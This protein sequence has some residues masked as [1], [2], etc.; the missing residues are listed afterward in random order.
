MDEYLV[1]YKILLSVFSGKNLGEEFNK[2]I[3]EN[4]ELNI[5]KI[6]D[7]S[8]GVL[9]Y[10]F[11]LDK[12]LGK[13]YKLKPD[14]NILV[15][16]FIA[17]YEIKYTKKPQY[18]ISNECVNL[19][20]RLTNNIKIKNFVNAI[21]RN[22][23]RSQKEIESELKNNLEYSYNFPL[24]LID[25]IKINNPDKYEEIIKNLNSKSKLSLR[26]NIKKTSL[27][28]YCQVL[29]DNNI[30]YN[31][32]D[33]T[34]ILY[35]NIKIENIPLFKEGFVS[36]QDI[37]A[38]KLNKILEFQDNSYVLDA[39]AAPGG[40]TCQ[41]LENNNVKLLAIDIDKTRIK[42][43]EQNL[44]R[45]DLD[46]TVICGDASKT[47]WWNSHK[48]DTI[49][50]DLPCSATGT[51]KKNPD[52]KINRRDTDIKNFVEKQRKIILNLWNILKDDGCLVYITCSI[53]PEENQDNIK[54][55][56]DKLKNAKQI[57]ELKILPDEYGDG[58]Y[59]C[60]LKK[61]TNES[62]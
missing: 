13:L 57:K 36:I 43:I 19:V 2:N 47:N 54:Y 6:K 11:I 12:I 10:Y 24:W 51:I 5:S 62:L 8:S 7:T 17:I 1:I 55:L 53:I 33:E 26:I 44:E 61:V 29:K 27:D 9:R 20:Y 18:A 39:C 34:I 59:Y 16:L 41:I 56:L 35:K 45:L 30:L 46:A 42:K 28:K 48:F 23:L 60:L 14:N 15:I 22:F 31:I 50:A 37:N 4:K 58:F 25:K 52:I 49:I 3:K 40:K 32:K 38:Q 21:I